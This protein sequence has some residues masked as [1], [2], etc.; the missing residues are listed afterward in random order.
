[1]VEWGMWMFY[2]NQDNGLQVILNY[3]EKR[4]KE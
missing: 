4:R 3:G 1:M 2:A